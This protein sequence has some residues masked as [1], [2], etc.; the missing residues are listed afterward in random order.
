MEGNMYC[1]GG[2]GQ[3]RCC[4]VIHIVRDW[5]SSMKWRGLN[6]SSKC[7]CG[8]PPRSRSRSRSRIVLMSLCSKF[9]ECGPVL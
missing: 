6:C 9:E 3:V 2:S 4:R 7:A 1:L 5:F 8:L